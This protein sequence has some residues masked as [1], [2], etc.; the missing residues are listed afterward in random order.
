MEKLNIFEIIVL[1]M[2]QIFV[3]VQSKLNKEWCGLEYISY[4]FFLGPKSW[5]I[6][7]YYIIIFALFYTLF[8]D[9]FS[10]NQFIE[11]G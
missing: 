1:K 11:L 6:I 10:A 4:M 5:V 7:I 2:L 3:W 9:E 8:Y